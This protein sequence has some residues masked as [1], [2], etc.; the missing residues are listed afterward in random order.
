MRDSATARTVIGCVVTLDVITWF[1][2]LSLLSVGKAE[3]KS[4][5]EQS[6]HTWKNLKQIL[7]MTFPLF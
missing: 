5:Y 6:T 4:V 2:C 7:G 1:E 3:R